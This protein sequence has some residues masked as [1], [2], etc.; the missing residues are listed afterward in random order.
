MDKHF[1]A[2]YRLTELP[3]VSYDTCFH[4]HETIMT[5]PYV[6]NPTGTRYIETC[7]EIFAL[8]SFSS[9]FNP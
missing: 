4:D 1:C 6:Q 7:T 2:F 3:D 9:G 8:L 5:L